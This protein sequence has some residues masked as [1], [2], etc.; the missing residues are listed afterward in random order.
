M[1]M[2]DV[3][4]AQGPRGKF[5]EELSLDINKRQTVHREDAKRGLFLTST[6]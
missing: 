2:E 4:V 3:Y 5:W 6:K 1:Q